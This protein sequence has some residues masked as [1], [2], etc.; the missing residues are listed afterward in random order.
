MS[1]YTKPRVGV[2][3]F[4]SLTKKQE[5]K[6]ILEECL[7]SVKDAYELVTINEVITDS[8]Q[9]KKYSEELNKS[10]LDATIIIAATVGTAFPM[11]ISA[12][13]SNVPFLIW[14]PKPETHALP[15]ALQVVDT[16]RIKGIKFRLVYSSPND[17]WALNRID[18]FIRAA[19]TI[20]ELKTTIVGQIGYKRPELICGAYDERR[21]FAALGVR[22]IQMGLEETISAFEKCQRED[23]QIISEKVLKKT[24]L[25]NTTEEDLERAVRLYLAVKQIINKYDLNSVAINGYPKFNNLETSAA[26]ACSLLNSEGVMADYEGD[27]VSVTTMTLLHYLSNKPVFLAE[28]YKVDLEE[29]SVYFFHR[30]APFTLQKS[31][32]KIWLHGSRI[33]LNVPIEMN[34]VTIIRMDRMTFKKFH[35][36]LGEVIHTDRTSESMTEIK[37]KMDN[38]EVFFDKI[39][40]NHHSIVPGNILEE[41]CVFCELIGAEIILNDRIS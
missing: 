13:E 26:L 6:E 37:I 1:S 35:V 39:L 21:L 28:P 24:R 27:V 32:E 5:G 40:G 19:S 8:V 23:I 29:K 9:A 31:E 22:D 18:S 10:K 20:R 33:L 41:F 38:V 4:S 25:V 14:T 15:S 16:L 3:S 2:I 36:S 12:I 7:N 11:L 30:S 34:T 17:K